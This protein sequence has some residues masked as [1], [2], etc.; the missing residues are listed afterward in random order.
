MVALLGGIAEII[1][2]AQPERTMRVQL[3]ALAALLGVYASDALPQSAS[4]APMMKTFTSSAEIGGLIEKATSE[5]KPD[6]AMIAEPILLLAPYH[7]NLEYRAAPAPAA[8]HERDAEMMFV[9]DGT[10]TIITGGKLVD[11]KRTNAA[12]LSGSSI[13]GGNS[14]PLSKGD[15]LI[16]PENT[17]HQILPG[18]GA[19]IVLMTLHVPR[20]MST[21][22]P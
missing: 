20:P 22:W 13:A 8:V 3:L 11:E 18:G 17:P 6:Q 16:V 15:F 10:G 19:P 7:A 1:S 9:I 2:S 14:R 5:R 12:N 21:P 4:E